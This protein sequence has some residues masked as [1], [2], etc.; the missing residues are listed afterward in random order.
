MGSR[1]PCKAP[2]NFFYIFISILTANQCWLTSFCFKLMVYFTAG[3]SIF[4]YLL[5]VYITAEFIKIQTQ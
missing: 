3:E 1:V 2:M 5:P 4:L